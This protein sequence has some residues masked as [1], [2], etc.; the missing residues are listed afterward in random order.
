MSLENSRT[1]K[2]SVARA[3]EA[4]ERVV[5]EAERKWGTDQE[6]AGSPAKDCEEPL[7]VVLRR[8]KM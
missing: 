1:S 3:E 4:R 8:G 2:V 7:W 5:I 6:G